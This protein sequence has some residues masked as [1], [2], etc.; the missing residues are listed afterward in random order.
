MKKRRDIKVRV[1]RERLESLCNLHHWLLTVYDS[2]DEYEEL[3]RA[4]VEL[5]YQRLSTILNKTFRTI[6]IDFTDPEAKAFCA[7]WTHWNLDHDVAGK[8]VAQDLVRKIDM[9]RSHIM[10]SELS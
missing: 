3:L 6:L 7:V 9:A 10:L 4:H 1:N 5:M 8:V 2:G